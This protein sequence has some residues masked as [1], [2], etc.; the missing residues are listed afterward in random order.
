MFRSALEAPDDHMLSPSS[1]R[2]DSP[3]CASLYHNELELILLHR[4]LD[5]QDHS[6]SFLTSFFQMELALAGL[7]LARSSMTINYS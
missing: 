1:K 6:L 2:A 7:A 5:K 4:I 3:R